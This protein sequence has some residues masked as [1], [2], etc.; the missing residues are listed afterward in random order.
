MVFDILRKHKDSKKNFLERKRILG[1]LD[2]ALSQRT[3][4]HVRFDEKISNLS[5]VSAQIQSVEKQF[6]IFEIFGVS[7]LKESFV[8]HS[9]YC[10]LRLVDRD[11]K[12]REIFY[13]FSVK[14]LNVTNKNGIYISTTIPDSI[15]GSQRRKSLRIK[16]D[17]NKFSHLAFW[18]YDSSGGFDIN[19]PTLSH[20]LFKTSQV[21]LDNV[22]A[23][24]MRIIICKNVLKDYN[25]SISK[26]DRFIVF[27]DFSEELNKLRDDY[28]L[29]MKINN[30]ITDPVTGATTLGMEYIAN[31]IR[32]VESG[33]IAWN[34][35][36]DNVIDDLAQRIYHWH[37]ALYRDK[38]LV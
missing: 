30:I 14:I 33:K 29:V 11:N 5:G 3:K 37:L 4:I 36:E 24:G 8:G 23:G 6:L 32:Q 12:H 19:K 26:G 27:F 20:S 17:L 13:N 18:K 35:V 28:W 7:A 16:P 9:I 34:K 25:I 21:V 31:G 38:G 10:F 22:S 1:L 15:D 2:E